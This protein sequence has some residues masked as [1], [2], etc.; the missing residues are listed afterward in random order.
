MIGELPHLPSRPEWACLICDAAWPCDTA[1]KALL[2]EYDGSR[3]SLS[4]YLAGRLNDAIN[5]HSEHRPGSVPNLYERFL[6][7]MT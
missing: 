4:V 1:R 3:L 6:G 2:I 5:D 7:W